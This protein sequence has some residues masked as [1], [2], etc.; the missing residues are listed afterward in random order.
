MKYIHLLLTLLILSCYSKRAD[1]V[2]VLMNG[3]KIYNNL[4]GSNYESIRITTISG[5]PTWYSFHDYLGES[6][7]QLKRHRDNVIIHCIYYPKSNKVRKLEVRNYEGR[8]PD[9]LDYSELEELEISNSILEGD[10]SMFKPNK[11]NKVDIYRSF[12]FDSLVDLIMFQ[13]LKDLSLLDNETEFYLNTD[14]PITKIIYIDT[15]PKGY[16]KR[17]NIDVNKLSKLDSLAIKCFE[18]SIDFPNKKMK[19]IGITADRVDTIY[20]DS[21]TYKKRE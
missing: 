1:K 4:E 11:I 18:C 21:S 14:L 12:L 17:I 13:S 15:S 7:L 20:N 9:S 2:P 10:V 3:E 5:N 16:I 19:M 6:K 8:L